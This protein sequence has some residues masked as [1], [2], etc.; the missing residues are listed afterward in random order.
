MLSFIIPNAISKHFTFFGFWCLTTFNLSIQ[1]LINRFRVLLEQSVDVILF[2]SLIISLDP[3]RFHLQPTFVPALQELRSASLFF[4]RYLRSSYWYFPS[5]L[6]SLFFFLSKK[7]ICFRSSLV[8][9]FFISSKVY[10]F[11]V[12]RFTV[13]FEAY[14]I[15]D[16]DDSVFNQYIRSRYIIYLDFFFFSILFALSVHLLR[17]FLPSSLNLFF[18]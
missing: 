18:P 1:L 12:L 14:F 5:I 9:V 2:N 17:K 6:I 3:C 4:N 8:V 13:W 10:F 16:I 11:L 7:L 15:S